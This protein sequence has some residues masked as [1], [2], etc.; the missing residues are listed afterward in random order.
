MSQRLISYPGS[1]KPFSFRLGETRRFEST[2]QP[3][4]GLFLKSRFAKRAASHEGKQDRGASFPKKPTGRTRRIIAAA[5]QV[6]PGG[7]PVPNRQPGIPM[8]TA[9]N[10]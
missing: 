5:L 2:S 4:A 9:K 3:S 1:V 7:T 8:K 10:S 6:Y